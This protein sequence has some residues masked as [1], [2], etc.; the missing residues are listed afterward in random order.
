MTTEAA[1]TYLKD[2]QAPDFLVDTIDLFFNINPETA[3][4]KTIVMASSRYKRNPTKKGTAPLVLDGVECKLLSVL[5]DGQPLVP[6]AYQLGDEKLIIPN[7]PDEF[8]LTIETEI[9]PAH[10]TSLEGLYASGPML[11]TQCEA[12][13]FRR[14]TFYPDR[15]DVMAKFSTT[16]EADKATYPI[17]LS[18]GNL[19]M[20]S[21]LEGGRHRVMWKDPFPKPCYLFALVAGNLAKFESSFTT[22]DGQDVLLQI[23]C[24]EG[25]Q[26][27]LSHA[28]ESLKKSMRWD[29]ER[30]GRTYDLDRFMI[31]ATPFFNA[32]A[33]E[34]KGLNIFNDAYLLGRPET[35]TDRDLYNI[36][37]V[38][39]H[40]YFHNW[41][42]NRVT[43]R[44][45]FQLSLKEGFTVFRDQEFSSD[46]HSPAT[47][48]IGHVR[49]LRA[50]QF[51]EDAGPLA[52]PIR[53]D[54]FVTIDN[55]YTMTV[56]EKGAEVVRML[57]TIFGREGFRKGTDLYFA[58][59]DGQAVT[60]DDFSQAI[61]DANPEKGKE[62][63]LEAFR[64]WYA[65]AGTPRLKAA[66]VY[67]EK[68][69]K[70]TLTLEQMVP[71]TPR[72]PE[73]KPMVLPVSCALLNAA[74][75]D[76]E[77]T[78]K[79][80]LL[81]K[82]ADSFVFENVAEKPVLSIL[83]DFSA[84]VILE[85]NRSDE[86]GAFLAAH[87]S[88]GFSRWDAM[89]KLGAS[90][91]QRMIADVQ[92]GKTPNASPLFQKTFAALLARAD[93]DPDFAALCMALPPE[94]ELGQAM[95]R[96]GKPVDIDA[97]HTAREALRRALADANREA[98]MSLYFEYKNVDALAF[99]GA[100]MGKRALKNSCL[101][102]LGTLNDAD[103]DAL[104]FA[105]SES[106]KNMTDA[107][108]ALSVLTHRNIPQRAK[109]FDA[110]YQK[111]QKD[112]LVLDKWF[113]LQA[114]ADRDDV[115]SSV[116][117]LMLHPAF[118]ITNPNMV[119]AVI[120]GF[121]ANLVHFHR[122]DGQG[123]KFLADAVLKLDGLNA[124]IAGRILPPLTRLKDYDAG[125]AA[126]MRAELMRI[127]A[128][129]GLSKNVR[130]VAE[131]GIASATP[132]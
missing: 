62:V 105:Q 75:H 26:D 8:T 63:G 12:E 36:E 46:M 25:K 68:A 20:E 102:Y 65:Q 106:A 122:R 9:D 108:A 18:N 45:W 128:K 94:V 74:G 112:K 51:T 48:R 77:G 71:P 124:Q 84:P 129:D 126:L 118:N 113:S 131:A 29:E 115:L 81:K 99:D 123:Y 7:V 16:I 42:G 55:F 28:M 103:I 125:R 5:L 78:N 70:Y 130:E 13:G 107:V 21:T 54:S 127:L 53:P 61:F 80:L 67:D 116:K 44:D 35:A 27:Q 104:A 15:P 30:F 96:E 1:R 72:Q 39:A 98:L 110:F 24:E 52:H 17:L 38:V 56:Y 73:K 64:L 97:I 43:C 32:G 101:A 90:E 119:Y 57:Q 83:R 10:N 109:A 92:G 31:V 69:Q 47:E 100:T 87:D 41:S 59:Y 111:W 11:C 88:N 22:K 114:G 120:R 117:E 82:A 3:K 2:Y 93:E 89:Q 34:N 79:V 60:C 19:L 6:S 85:M 76:M 14:I 49:G 4:D 50:A 37:S 58:R 132:A 121:A 86:E 33:M 91:L 66:G 40:E 95:L 23:F